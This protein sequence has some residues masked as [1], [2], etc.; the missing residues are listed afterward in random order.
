MLLIRSPGLV[1]H[2]LLKHSVLSVHVTLVGLVSV[3]KTFCSEVHSVQILGFAG[4]WMIPLI[5]R[6]HK[7][8]FELKPGGNGFNSV[9]QA[10]EQ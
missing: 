7:R 3:D 10:T 2:P 4:A 8:G 9:T 1:K 5:S 6:T